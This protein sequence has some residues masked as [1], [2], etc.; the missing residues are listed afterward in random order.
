M[1]G[2][3]TSKD[4]IFLIWGGRSWVAGHLE[5]LLRS[6]GRN[7]HMTTVRMEDREGVEKELERIKPTHVFNCAGVTGRPNVD[8]CEDHK[9][10]TLTSNLAGTIN[11]ANCCAAVGI[12]LTVFATGCKEA[13]RSSRWK[14]KYPC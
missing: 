9:Q 3:N 2:V 6:Q 8:W 14:L 11:L 1:P 13:L 12:H 10:E 5:T 4:N 7:V